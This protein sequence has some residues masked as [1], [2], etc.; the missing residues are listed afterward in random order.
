MMKRDIYWIGDLY[1][2]LNAMS[3]DKLKKTLFI[4]EDCP[5][6]E[7][8]IDENTRVA[9]YSTK[10]NGVFRD[11]FDREYTVASSTIGCV[12]AKYIQ[13]ANLLSLGH[14]TGIGDDFLTES[15]NGKIVFGDVEI[16]TDHGDFI[17]INS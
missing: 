7:V 14:I 13:D 6:G 16:Q 1:Y 9:L 4:N 3:W 15:K 10:R 12:R 8:N 5:G 11:C 2:I 17:E